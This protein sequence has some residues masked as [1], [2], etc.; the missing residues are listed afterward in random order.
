MLDNDKTMTSIKADDKWLDF[1]REKIE[2]ALFDLKHSKSEKL[3]LK[4]S[5]E[6]LKPEV[7]LKK[8]ILLQTPPSMK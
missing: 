7:Q 1:I 3:P 5:Q 4:K 8:G 2:A 6:L